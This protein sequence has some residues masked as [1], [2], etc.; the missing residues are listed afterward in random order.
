MMIVGY[1]KGFLYGLISFAYTGLSILLSWFASPVFAKLFP[2]IDLDKLSAES[3]MLNKLLNLNGLINNI[4]YFIIIFLVLKIMYIFLSLLLKSLN[5]LPVIGKFNK[6]LGTLFGIFNAT[7]ITLFIS[8]LFSLP[9]FANGNDIKN[10][11]ILKYI[12]GFT[13]DVITIIANN[14][15]ENKINDTSEVFDVEEYRKELEN[16]LNSLKDNE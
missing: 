13:S 16:W 1:N 6:L 5:N 14:I 10:K 2:L 9:L 8:M 12:N 3:M 11:T 7:I 4:T 15:S